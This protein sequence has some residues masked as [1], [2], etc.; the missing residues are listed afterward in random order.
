MDHH[1]HHQDH[2]GGQSKHHHYHFNPLDQ[3]RLVL[4]PLP[5]PKYLGLADIWGLATGQG[6]TCIGA[7]GH[8]E[9]D[10]EFNRIHDGLDDKCAPF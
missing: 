1:L 6:Y 5:N 9:N 3:G 7:N 2:R 10:D 4:A 8:H